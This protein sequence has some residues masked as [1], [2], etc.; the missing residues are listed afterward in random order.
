MTVGTY[1]LL[2]LSNYL[3]ETFTVGC[4]EDLS[5]NPAH[6]VPHIFQKTMALSAKT[7][8]NWQGLRFLPCL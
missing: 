4:Q 2:P 5:S 1:I 8:K 3:G 6:W 7:V